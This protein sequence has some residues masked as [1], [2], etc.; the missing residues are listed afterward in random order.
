MRKAL[1]AI[2]DSATRLTGADRVALILFEWEAGEVQQFLRGGQGWS[3]VMTTIGFDELSAGLSGWVL[4][5]GEV[6]L[7]P[8]SPPDPRESPAAQSRR[9]ETSCGSI[10][11]AP[12]GPRGH[13]VGTITAIHRLDHPDFL[14]EDAEALKLFC[15]FAADRILLLRAQAA[16]FDAQ[17]AAEVA[18]RSRTNFLS[19]LSHELR[20]PLNGILGF[21]HLL[22]VSRLDSSQRSM[23]RT[24]AQSGQRL[25]STVDNLLELAQFE[26]GQFQL[27]VSP[28]SP[29]SVLL[30][31]VSKNEPLAKEKVLEWVVETGP[32]VP[33][34][35]QGDAVRL[36]L[37]WNHIVSNAVKF[38]DRGSISVLLEAKR[39]TEDRYE[40]DLTVEDTGIGMATDRFGNGFVPFQQED[41]S[42]TR[43]FGGTGLG[44]A[45]TDRIARKMGGGL[46]LWGEPGVGTRVRVR[47]ELEMEGVEDEPVSQLRVLLQDPDSLSRLAMVS[48]LE[49]LGHRVDLV[50]T[51]EQAE[52]RLETAT[53]EAVMVEFSSDDPTWGRLAKAAAGKKV[54]LVGLAPLGLVQPQAA[55]WTATIMKPAT[56][57]GL[58][59]VLKHCLPKDKR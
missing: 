59:E 21:S 3:E 31:V 12:L 43:K 16:V 15:C 53:Y 9:R 7:S 25:L 45:L 52:E 18:N 51:P 8:K 57:L 35:L 10:L 29:E 19:N 58:Q 30:S 33:P 36:G 44:L 23:V 13:H 5:T 26:S 22:D 11:V 20:T 32:G 40:L 1:Q 49:K 48:M 50:S 39:L 6:A 24:I 56:Y 38:T 46:G 41:S 27:E 34:I 17:T 54:L 2:V 42:P 14:P 28:F 4:Q 37:A 55:A 47:V